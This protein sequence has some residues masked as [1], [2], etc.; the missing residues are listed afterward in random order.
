M[1]NVVISIDSNMLPQ[2]CRSRCISL[3]NKIFTNI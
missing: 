1:A 2:P 3:E